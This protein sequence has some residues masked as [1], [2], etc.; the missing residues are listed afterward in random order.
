[1]VGIVDHQVY[2]GIVDHQV[3]MKANSCGTGDVCLVVGSAGRAK[4]LAMLL[5]IT[6][7]LCRLH[8]NNHQLHKSVYSS[9]LRVLASSTDCDCARGERNRNDSKVVDCKY[10]HTLS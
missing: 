2:I 7:V 1:M 9:S 4:S 3:Y 8:Y 5:T 6:G 10:T